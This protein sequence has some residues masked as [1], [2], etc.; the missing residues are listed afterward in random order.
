[1][2]QLQESLGG[3]GPRAVATD[4]ALRLAETV[5]AL[6]LKHGPATVRHC[7]RLIE[8]LRD[9]LDELGGEGETGP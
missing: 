7:L 6:A 2:E 9:L 5:R 3:P 8:G 1:M 4:D